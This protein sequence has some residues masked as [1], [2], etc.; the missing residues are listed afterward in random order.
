MNISKI[1][2]LVLIGLIFLGL[3][4]GRVVVAGGT[5][6]Q[7]HLDRVFSPIPATLRQQLYGRLILLIRAQKQQNWADAYELLP[8]NLKGKETKVQFVKRQSDLS[9]WQLVDFEPTKTVGYEAGSG[10]V[11]NGMWD[12][13]GCAL[14]Q[15]GGKRRAYEAGISARL[16]DG[17]WF[18]SGVSLITAVDGALQTCKFRT[19]GSLLRAK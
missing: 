17:Q 5:S 6:K 13:L 19:T 15:E 18:L 10:I 1:V 3:P 2:F 12:V 8:R 14:I 11:T 9:D 16:E 4:W 7:V